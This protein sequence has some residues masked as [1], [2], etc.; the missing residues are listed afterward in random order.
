MTTTAGGLSIEELLAQIRS[1]IAGS[2]PRAFFSLK[3][4]IESVGE[5]KMYR[6]SVQSENG[7]TS[8]SLETELSSSCTSSQPLPLSL[9]HI[10]IHGDNADDHDEL[11]EGLHRLQLDDSGDQRQRSITASADAED[12]SADQLTSN[13]DAF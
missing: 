10:N 4:G 1:C 2:L 5:K 11:A 8:A 13:R 6:F 7:L 12:A 3:I 9:S